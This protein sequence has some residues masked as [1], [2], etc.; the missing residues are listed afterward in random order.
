M[1]TLIILTTLLLTLNFSCVPP[2]REV[3]EEVHPTVN[4]QVFYNDLSPYGHWMR[5]PTYGYVW[6]P[7][8]DP[9][10]LP[11]SSHGHWVWT[12]YGWTWVSEYP[13]GWAPFHYGRWDFDPA[14]GWFWLPD[15]VW[16]PA[17]VVW[18]EYPGYYGWAPLRP[19]IAITIVLGGGYIPPDPWW[20]FCHR[21]YFGRHDMRD[22]FESR[23]KIGRIN[24][25]EGRAINNTFKGGR[26]EQVFLTGPGKDN[27]QKESGEPVQRVTIE[28]NS[29]PGES[30]KGNTWSVYHPDVERTPASSTQP[31]PKTVMTPEEVTKGRQNSP[32]TKPSVNPNVPPPKLPAPRTTPKVRK[33][34]TPKSPSPSQPNQGKPAPKRAPAVKP[35][36]RTPAP[37]GVPKTESK[38]KKESN[39]APR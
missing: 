9:D 11:Y 17:W 27:V 31:V 2:Q 1:K 28:D 34:P 32:S 18:R 29:K 20:T 4:F 33:P 36:P 12:D 3:P 39:Q 15:N 14:Y 38:P 37:S 25:G 16:G 21:N 26:S 13:W 8:D 24:E 6:L 30:L 10:F 5:H 23:K 19:G 22:H 35:T 7:M